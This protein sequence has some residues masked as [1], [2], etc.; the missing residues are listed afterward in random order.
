MFDKLLELYTQY[1]EDIT[2]DMRAI[3]L[4][5]DKVATG[6]LLR[7]IG[8][9]VKET[10]PGVVELLFFMDE[11]GIFVDE[12]RKPGKQP[13]ISKIKEWCAI[14]GLPQKAA[15]PIARNIGKF[16]I[17]PTHFFQVPVSKRMKELGKEI[18]K[19]SVKQIT[20]EIKKEF[21]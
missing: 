17:K 6:N 21:K 2:D 12:G 15:F 1:G 7:S 16:G 20:E 14:K 8:Y 11:Y 4:S 13:P 10:S 9:S 5:K 18:E 19:L 3:L